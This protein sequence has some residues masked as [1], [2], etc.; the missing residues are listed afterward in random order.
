MRL[1]STPRWRLNTIGTRIANQR[2]A[3]ATTALPGGTGSDIKATEKPIF[4]MRAGKIHK[5]R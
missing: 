2:P 4:V 1:S 3:K 5:N